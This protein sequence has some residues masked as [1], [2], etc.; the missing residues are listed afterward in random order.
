LRGTLHCIAGGLQRDLS[1]LQWPLFEQCGRYVLRDSRWLHLN[2]F[3]ETVKRRAHGCHTFP[4]RTLHRAAYPT[5][6]WTL[7]PVYF[8][9]DI[10]KGALKG[11]SYLCPS[12]HSSDL[13]LPR[14][15]MVRKGIFRS[16]RVTSIE[17][18]VSQSF[19]HREVLAWENSYASIIVPASSH[20]HEEDWSQ[21]PIPHGSIPVLFLDVPMCLDPLM[22]INLHLGC[23]TSMHVDFR[24]Y[25]SWLSYGLG[26]PCLRLSSCICDA[27]VG[28]K[29]CLM[30]SGKMHFLINIHCSS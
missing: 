19:P 25:K 24:V 11:S 10:L 26:L 16:S 21:V 6:A 15:S 29:M 1:K 9:H 12:S 13:K 20:E 8:A 7:Y 27:M 2:G 30:S 3:A 28:R 18:A 4:R 22:C 14:A 23:T 5:Y 17:L